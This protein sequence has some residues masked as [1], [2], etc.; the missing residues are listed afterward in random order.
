LNGQFLPESEASVPVSDRSFLYGDGL[1][2]TMRIYQG[3]PFG[4]FSHLARMQQGASLLGI[5]LPPERALRSQAEELILRNGLAECVLRIQVSRGSGPRGYVPPQVSSTLCLLTIGRVPTP[6]PAETLGSALV[7]SSW[8]VPSGAAWAS[9]K[10]VSRLIYV[11][12]SAE[13]VRDGA[14]EPLM[15]NE[16]D[17]VAEAAS[18]NFFWVTGG[19]VC[20]PPLESGALAGTTREWVLQQAEKLGYA[21]CERV[22]PCP[23]L[24]QVETAFL[25]SSVK[26]IQRLKSLDGR[27]LDNHKIVRELLGAYRACVRSECGECEAKRRSEGDAS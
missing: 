19:E 6:D 13:A 7:T 16:R 8:R 1:F 23:E 17:E 15:L 10:S 27:R 11:M 20:T 4:W 22:L 3:L 24:A 25:T 5:T 21:V 26:E 18:A 12:A 14:D 9:C 2:E